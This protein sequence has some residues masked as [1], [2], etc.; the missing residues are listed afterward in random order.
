MKSL[1]QFKEEAF[2]DELNKIGGMFGTIAKTVEK[3]PGVQG[4]HNF[5]KKNPATFTAG[6]ALAG[7]GGDVVGGYVGAH[8]GTHRAVTNFQQNQQNQQQS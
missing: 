4:L 6:A 1:L 5:A 2:Q 3:I 7:V 8:T